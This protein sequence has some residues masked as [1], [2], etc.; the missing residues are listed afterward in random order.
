MTRPEIQMC[1]VRK[2]SD[3]CA[4]IMTTFLGLAAGLGLNEHGLGLAGASAHTKV[5]YGD[6]GLPGQNLQF[7]LLNRCRNVGEARALFAEHSF[8]GQVM[9][10]KSGT[11]CYTP[12]HPAEVGWKLAE[13]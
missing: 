8:F 5:R 13:L 1:R 11:M 7:M 6:T 9:A 10:L 2:P 4:T 3:G 12:G